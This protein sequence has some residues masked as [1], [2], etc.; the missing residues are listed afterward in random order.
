M[1]TVLLTVGDLRDYRLRGIPEGTQRAALVDCESGNFDRRQSIFVLESA[2]KKNL[3]RNR[4]IS[5][6]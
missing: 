4:A 1:K 5:S 2:G 3:Q 6:E